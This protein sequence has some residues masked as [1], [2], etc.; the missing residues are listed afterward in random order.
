M[1]TLSFKLSENVDDTNLVE[2]IHTNL[3][4]LA[5]HTKYKNVQF[6]Q[7][8]YCLF[9]DKEKCAGNHYCTIFQFLVLDK[10]PPDGLSAFEIQRP[11]IF[12]NSF[13]GKVMHTMISDIKDF[14]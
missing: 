13:Y 8:N 6:Y 14:Q 10:K 2:K 9:H 3:S 4:E 12:T 5:R 1:H 11:T 7:L